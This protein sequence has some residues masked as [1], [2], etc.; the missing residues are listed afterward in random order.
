MSGKRVWLRVVLGLV[1]VG[2]VAA[3]ITT[4]LGVASGQSD[5]SKPMAMRG[6]GK[7]MGRGGLGGA[8][9]GEFTAPK[10][11]GGYQTLAM[12]VGE[13]TSVSSSRITV[14]SEDDFSRTYI[15]D[16]GTLV[17]AGNNGIADVN[18]GDSVRILAVVEGDDA[19]AVEIMDK[20][21]IQDLR[22]RWN[23]RAR[24]ESEESPAA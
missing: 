16:D 13:V 5:D 18:T 2:L 19:R 22:G 8:I 11:D 7:L 15:V 21:Q 1:G 12:Q 10:P 23:P 14:K 20:T 9:H 4:G 17:N 3:M 24:S 6:H